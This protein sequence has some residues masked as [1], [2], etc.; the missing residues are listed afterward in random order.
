MFWLNLM[1]SS[2]LQNNS[3]QGTLDVFFSPLFTWFQNRFLQFAYNY[4]KARHASVQMYGCQTSTQSQK[5]WDLTSCNVSTKDS[6][7]W[8]LDTSSSHLEYKHNNSPNGMN[9]H[10]LSSS[11]NYNPTEW[12]KR[13]WKLL[14]VI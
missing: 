2:I 10:S 8:R 7:C 1:S 14:K 11:I 3:N 13:G 12:L 4:L 6:I 5:V 9:V